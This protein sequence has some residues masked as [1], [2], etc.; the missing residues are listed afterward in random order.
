M[1]I[2]LGLAFVLD[3]I[4]H[5]SANFTAQTLKHK[6]KWSPMVYTCMCIQIPQAYVRISFEYIEATASRKQTNH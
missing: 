3:T 2:L 6:L 4:V 5:V 1:Y